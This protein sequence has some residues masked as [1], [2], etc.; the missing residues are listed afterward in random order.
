MGWDGGLT[1]T[2]MKTGDRE[3]FDNHKAGNYADCIVKRDLETGK[4]PL[5]CAKFF[6]EHGCGRGYDLLARIIVHEHDI[7]KEGYFDSSNESDGSCSGADNESDDSSSNDSDDND[8]S[9]SKYNVVEV[10]FDANE[11][12]EI[13]SDVHEIIARVEV[14]C[15]GEAMDECNSYPGKFEC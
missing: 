8:S 7:M 10:D 11:C 4:F 5:I 2:N 6:V 1:I 9:R 3:H 15:S 12:E 13:P 14:Y